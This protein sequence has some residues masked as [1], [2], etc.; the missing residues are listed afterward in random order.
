MTVNAAPAAILAAALLLPACGGGAERED[1]RTYE[2]SV[3]ALMAED[4]DVGARLADL[5]ADL[6]RDT[7]GAEA[8]V[9]YSRSDAGPFY[10]RFREAASK[11]PARAE[12]LAKVHGLLLEYLDQRTAFLAAIEGFLAV[13]QG[14]AMERL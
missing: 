5:R 3:E 11:A 14:G 12:R 4:A 8:M 1:L 6:L 7:A 10:A 2:A 13:E 9:A